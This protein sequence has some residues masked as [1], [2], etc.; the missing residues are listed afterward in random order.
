MA[1]SLSPQRLHRSASIF[2]VRAC[3]PFVG[4]FCPIG[5]VAA[6]RRTASSSEAVRRRTADVAKNKPKQVS[7]VPA[8]PVAAAVSARR[9]GF[10]LFW[11]WG[12]ARRL[13]GPPSSKTHNCFSSENLIGFL[14]RATAVWAGAEGRGPGRCSSGSSSFSS[15]R[16]RRKT[17]GDVPCAPR[18]SAPDRRRSAARH[19]AARAERRGGAYHRR[20]HLLADHPSLRSFET[21]A[22][23]DSTVRPYL[24]PSTESPAPEAPAAP[25][26]FQ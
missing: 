11:Q 6:Q 18:I 13:P 26:Q 12:S 14:H 19:T 15:C 4:P 2:T 7:C 9:R 23:T 25:N 22:A 8:D 16:S 24:S 10:A 17:G 5:Q 3:T 20:H 21:G 1:I